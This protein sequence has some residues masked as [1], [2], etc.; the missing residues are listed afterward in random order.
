MCEFN[1]YLETEGRREKI[2]KSVIVV[3]L[4]EGTVVL[5]DSGGT[6]TKVEKAGIIVVDTLM[7]ELVLKKV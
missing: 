4:K 3:K 6:L 2:A 1:V 7:Q 5:M